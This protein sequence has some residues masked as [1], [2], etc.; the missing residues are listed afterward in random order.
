MVFQMSIGNLINVIAI[1]IGTGICALNIFQISAGDWLKKEVKRYFQI[2]FGSVIV[3]IL[4][5]LV[6]QLL[7]GIDGSGVRVA[8][9]T[10]TFLEFLASGFMVYLISLLVTFSANAKHKKGIGIV[11]F[12][13]LVVHCVLLIAAQF[14]KFYYDF[15]AQNTYHRANLY[16]LSNL[17]HV[18]M[19]CLDI[20]ILIRY[21]KNFKKRVAISLWVYLL[22]PLFA[23]LLQ[24]FVADVQFIIIATIGGAAFMYTTIMQDQVEQYEQQKAESNRLE[25]ELGMASSIQAD[26]LPNIFP[27]F[28][29]RPEFDVY[30]SMNPA[31]EVGGD[32]YDFFLIDETH[33]GIVMADV[34]GKGVPA[35]LFMMVSKILV[36]NY[37]MMTDSPAAALEA[38]NNQIC[39]NNREEMFVTVW[40][41][42]L[43]LESGK[44]ISA[45][46]GHECPALYR[47]DTG[48]ELVREKHGLVIGAMQGIKYRDFE[49]TLP[50]DSKLFLY[51]D[52]VPEATN[53]KQQQFGTDAMLKTLREAQ[54][55][56]PHEILNHV[57][58]SV[59]EFTHG[60]DQFDD[61][62]MLCVHYKGM[63]NQE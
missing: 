50:P 36:Q 52:G 9:F 45:N 14:G 34:S 27:A 8:L 33:L 41:G 58:E 47:P 7:D 35:A 43:D 26:M 4:M 25:T 38:V 60:A 20:Y 42:I 48:F 28:P 30:A 44:L 11:L 23:M 3:Y 13:L 2:F 32:F 40:L 24:A 31:K 54:K 37:A 5:H 22:A 17:I 16:L 53:A 61:I 12:A 56:T 15:D 55:Q 63:E 10:T 1:A 6:R 21:R 59:S 51:T 57:T 62:T 49:I 19:M 18:A 46:A 39:L 29:E